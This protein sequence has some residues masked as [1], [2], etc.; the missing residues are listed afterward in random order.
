V[1]VAKTIS[2]EVSTWI[3]LEKYQKKHGIEDFSR[4]V[5]E[6]IKKGLKGDKIEE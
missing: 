4:A 1:K 2:L 5:E 3:E 6:V